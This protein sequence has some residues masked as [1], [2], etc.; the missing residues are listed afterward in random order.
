MN[1]SIAEYKKYKEELANKPALDLND[2]AVLAETK[3]CLIS[4]IVLM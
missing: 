3:G 1:A 4:A 2:P